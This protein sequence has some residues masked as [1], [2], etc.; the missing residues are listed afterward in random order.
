MKIWP[1]FIGLNTLEK[2]RGAQ[3]LH[4]PQGHQHVTCIH[5]PGRIGDTDQQVANHNALPRSPAVFAKS[6]QYSHPGTLGWFDEV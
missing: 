4:A 2:C 1:D 5:Q 3:S 6:N